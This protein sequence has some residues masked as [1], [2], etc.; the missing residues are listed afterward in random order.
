MFEKKEHPTSL[1]INRNEGEVIS[2]SLG[3]EKSEHSDQHLE[4]KS[5]YPKLTLKDA[6]RL[7]ELYILA[8]VFSC[9]TKSVHAFLG[10]YKV[11]NK[12]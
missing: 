6:I 5:S 4:N 11:K 9:S 12:L 1:K 3:H 8:L 2:M 7:K 10:Y